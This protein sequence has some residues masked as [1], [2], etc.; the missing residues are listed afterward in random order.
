MG[1]CYG[2][3]VRRPKGSGAAWDEVSELGLVGG[4]PG[5]GG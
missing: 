1:G 4:S 3:V 5:G 2:G